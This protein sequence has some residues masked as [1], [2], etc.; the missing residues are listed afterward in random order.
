MKPQGPEGPMV[1]D[2]K[3]VYVRFRDLV[4]PNGSSFIAYLLR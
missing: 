4:T 2:R 3:I 1:I